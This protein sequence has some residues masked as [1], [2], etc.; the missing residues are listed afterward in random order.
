LSSP[1]TET[2]E[3]CFN[4]NTDSVTGPK[5]TLLQINSATTTSGGRIP[6]TPTT[7]A[8]HQR[9]TREG[10]ISKKPGEK[11]GGSC[12]P[13]AGA[14]IY[15]ETTKSTPAHRNAHIDPDTEPTSGT[16]KKSK[17]KDESSELAEGEI[18]IATL[19]STL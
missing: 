14:A 11:K 17:K 13:V 6:A 16:R 9:A 10:N 15:T 1:Q 12:G 8:Q 4:I 3:S 7:N 19:R 2:G 5:A 18:Y